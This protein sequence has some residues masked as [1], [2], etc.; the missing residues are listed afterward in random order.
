MVLQADSLPL[1]GSPRRPH[2]GSKFGTLLRRHQLKTVD[3]LLILNLR[4]HLLLSAFLGGCQ[5]ETGDSQQGAH[6][7]HDV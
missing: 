7:D 1:F 3:L 6:H 4:W 2:P 5:A